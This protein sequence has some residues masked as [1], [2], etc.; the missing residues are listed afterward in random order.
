[1]ARRSF[2]TAAPVEPPAELVENTA[3]RWADGI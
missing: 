2:G 3:P 1:V